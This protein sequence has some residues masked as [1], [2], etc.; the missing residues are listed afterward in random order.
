MPKRSHLNNKA[1]S[2][3]EGRGKHPVSARA[4]C[5]DK[6]YVAG[7]KCTQVVSRPQLMLHCEYGLMI[8]INSWVMVLLW[9]YMFA[10]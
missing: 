2:R 4:L 3:L 9:T 10:K 1:L 8:I 7:F 5:D 6:M